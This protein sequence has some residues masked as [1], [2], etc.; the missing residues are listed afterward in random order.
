MVRF[1][2]SFRNYGVGE[3]AGFSKQHEAWLVEKN[4]ADKLVKE[5]AHADKTGTERSEGSKVKPTGQKT[6][7]GH[8]ADGGG[9]TAP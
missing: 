1:R 2:K 5:T 7:A 3:V 6:G 4:I 9:A 8:K